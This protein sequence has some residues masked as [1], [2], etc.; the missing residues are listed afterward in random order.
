MKNTT[1]LLI[2]FWLYL[3]SRMVGT[4]REYGWDN[5]LPLSVVEII[6]YIFIVVISLEILG[7]KE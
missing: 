5:P 2:M 4:I 7:S 6:L 1:K 3:I